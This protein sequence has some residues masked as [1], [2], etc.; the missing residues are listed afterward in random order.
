MIT[1]AVVPILVQ[2]G[3]PLLSTILAGATAILAMLF[4][5]TN[6]I[7]LCRESPKTLTALSA[8][9]LLAIWGGLELG[10]RR[11]AQSTVAMDW[12]QVALEIIRNGENA[13]AA[14][15]DGPAIPRNLRPAWE[16][17]QPG[18]SFLSTPV[19][20]AGRIYSASCQMD[21]GGTFGSIFCLDAQ[22]GKPIWQVDK[23]GG[24]D[25]KAFFSSPALTADGRYLVI[26]EGLHFDRECHLICLET[27]TGKLHWKI[28]VPK[29]HVESSPAVLGDLVVAGA[30]AIERNNHLPAEA[31]GY[32]FGVRIS[33]GKMLWKQ[34]VTDPESSP[35]ISS[36]GI[37]YIGSGIDG[38]AV[39]ALRIGSD[40]T[41]QEDG[42]RRVAWQTATS[43][44]ATGDALLGGELVF[45]GTGRG[46][47]VNASRDPA[48][49]VLAMERS[50]GKL[51]WKTE[52][53]DAVLGR[54]A[55]HEAKIICP[56]RNGTVVA[57]DRQD[58]RI[59]WSQVISHAPI[60]A[61]TKVLGNCVYAVSSDGFLAIL[62]LETGLLIEKHALND[63]AHPGRQNL[64]LSSP[65][66]AEGRVFVGTETGGLRCFVGS[67]AP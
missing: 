59:L 30:G 56:V 50:S 19:V 18:T 52:L 9:V 25:L 7:R 28:D 39:V 32:V 61:G 54:L 38:N 33:D 64:C 58:G 47:L 37:A 51:R 1:I 23:I 35:A 57:L 43:Y 4:R 40:E 15:A 36:N 46:D 2:A 26:G 45:I 20:F 34:G 14:R 31:A 6:W 60:L 16:F 22:T 29:N 10:H 11:S 67:S 3:A 13:N 55:V 27:E 5:P 53:G 12:A 42:V 48:G 41:L 24:Q 17:K 62:D 66:V 63:E 65:V 8:L 44:P 21:V 49:A